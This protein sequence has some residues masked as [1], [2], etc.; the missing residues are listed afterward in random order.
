[1]LH[2]YIAIL[3][4]CYTAILL[5]YCYIAIY[6]YYTSSVTAP[7]AAAAAAATATQ[8]LWCGRLA[9]TNKLL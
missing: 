3:L 5:L 6:T 2:R 7:T 9:R 4:Y 8:Q 1:M